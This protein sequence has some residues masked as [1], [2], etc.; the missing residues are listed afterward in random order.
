MNACKQHKQM[1]VKKKVY[2]KNDL[3]YICCMYFTV[4]FTSAFAHD[5]KPISFMHGERNTVII[6]YISSNQGKQLNILPRKTCKIQGSQ[7]SFPFQSSKH[8]WNTLSSKLASS[9]E[10]RPL[11]Q[12]TR[13]L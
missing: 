11:L 2:L 5:F 3:E 6:F 1:S 8:F 4:P 7:S 13:N 9:N 12:S 10:T